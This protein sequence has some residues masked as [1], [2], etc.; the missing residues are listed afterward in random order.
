[1]ARAKA[2]T[3]KPPVIGEVPS[4]EILLYLEQVVARLERLGDRIEAYATTTE[5]GG[6]DGPA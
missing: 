3:R 2:P 1:M 5:G 4:E 6:D